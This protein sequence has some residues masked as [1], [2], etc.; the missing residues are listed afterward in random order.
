[1]RFSAGGAAAAP[2][3]DA[4]P[5]VADA[6]GLLESVAVLIAGINHLG[7]LSPK[8]RQGVLLIEDK[9]GS[10]TTYEDA[11]VL[12]K[13]AGLRPDPT[14]EHNTYNEFITEVMG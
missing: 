5:I 7:E 14:R 6:A 1:M 8:L 11:E 9:V 12:A 10:G 4:A 3:E 13:Y 2:A